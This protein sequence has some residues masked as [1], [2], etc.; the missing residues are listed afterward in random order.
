[1]KSWI[2][3]NKKKYEDEKDQMGSNGGGGTYQRKKWG[4]NDGSDKKEKGITNN[5]GLSK[6]DGV[7]HMHC[8]KGC[9]WNKTHTTK[10]HGKFKATPPAYPSMLPPQHPYS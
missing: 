3:E 2:Q 8:N 9:G 5:S 4:T 1:M 10:F 6:F 7:W